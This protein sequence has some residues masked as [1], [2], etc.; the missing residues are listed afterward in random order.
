V[1]APH[2]LRAQQLSMS[3]SVAVDGYGSSSVSNGAER[4]QPIRG[5]RRDP[6][7]RR[8]DRYVAGFYGY[9]ALVPFALFS[10]VPVGYI[11]YTSFTRNDG[12]HPAVW[13]GLS[14]YRTLLHDN[15]WWS[16]VINTLLIGGGTVA[17][18][19]PLAL[20]LAVVLNSLGPRSSVFRTIYFVPHVMSLAVLSV[21]FYFLLRPVDGVINGIGEWFGLFGNVDWLGS[22]S[23]AMS[24]I[25]M[26]AVWH[27]FGINT[28]LLLIGL[29]SL[30]KEVQ[31]SARL[32]GASGWRVFWQ[33]NLP[34]MAPVLRIVVILAITSA[35]R[36]FDLVKVLT[37]GGPAGKTDVMF[38]YL[39]Q[40]FFSL[41]RGTQYGYGSAL[42]VAASL[43]IT[44]VAGFYL[45]AQRGR[46]DLGR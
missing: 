23:T 1:T 2:G 34:L 45:W 21:I 19:L 14:N 4:Q 24:S 41:T 3:K 35:M 39:F 18:E 17:V 31:E 13:I 26:V 36:M 12:V 29:Q 16:S 43:V 28:V 5:G 42:A 9:L 6:R 8:R 33:I 10:L 44:A 25:I 11:V 40:Y 32:D 20:L 27:G 7:W 22:R 37:D 30:P 38:T 46:G 15:V